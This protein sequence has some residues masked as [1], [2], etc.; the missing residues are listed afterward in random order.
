MLIF[1]GLGALPSPPSS[2]QTALQNASNTYGVPISLLQSVAYAESAYN[3]SVTSSAGAQGL[4]QIMPAN[5]AS[6]GV[7][8]PFD[9]QQ[10]ANAG[11]KYLAQLYT[12][13]GNW[14]TALIAYNEG[15]GNLS[16]KGPFASSQS[17]ASGILSNAGDL[18]GSQPA[19]TSDDSSTGSPVADTG[20]FDFSSLL[21]PL[22]DSGDDGVT[23]LDSSGNLTGY[24][25]AGIAAGIGL[26]V[27]G[28]TR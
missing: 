19:Q 18:T 12:Q 2:I 22:D 6:L 14:N 13:Y 28:M 11:A 9:P 27:W 26:L 3:P 5:D 25:W 17:Y 8:N 20:G 15:P 23:L 1:R 16:S 21:A 24:A 7:T 4:L 10:S